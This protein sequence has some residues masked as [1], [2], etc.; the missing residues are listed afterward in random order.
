MS[1]PHDWERTQIM[2]GSDRM[3]QCRA[4]NILGYG[5]DEYYPGGTSHVT[6][7]PRSIHCDMS[8]EEAANLSCDDA[9][10]LLVMS[11]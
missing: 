2:S 6:A 7:D 4:C 1:K 10:A 3:W 5:T 11:R 8:L 9:L